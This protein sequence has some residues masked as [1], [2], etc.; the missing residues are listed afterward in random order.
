M[1]FNLFAAASNA[2][3]DANL[4]QT[5]R[6]GITYGNLILQQNTKT[7]DGALI[8]NG[9]ITF[10]NT[11]PTTLALL[12]FDHTFNGG[13]IVNNTAAD[14][15][16][17][18]TSG[19]TFRFAGPDISQ[20]LNGSD[21]GTYTFHN[22]I[23]SNPGTPTA[24]RT[25][26]IQ[27]SCTV[28]GDITID[29]ALGDTINLLVVNIGANQLTK[30][31]ASGTLTAGAFTAIYTSG[32]S[33]FDNTVASFT[34]RSLAQNSIVRF[35][36]T[37]QNIPGIT[38]GT[39]EILGTGTKTV[40]GAMDING[41]LTR[42]ANNAVIDLGAFSHTLAGDLRINS[43]AL[44]IP[45]TSTLTLDGGNQSILFGA[46]NNVIA[47]GTGTK[48]L[49]GS[50]IVN[51][52]LTINN[53]VTFDA[54]IRSITL[55][56]NFINSGTGVFTQTTGTVTFNGTSASA[57][58][59]TTNAAS[60]FG[61]VFFNRPNASTSRTIQALSNFRVATNCS[62]GTGASNNSNVFDLNGF[63]VQVAG[64]WSFQGTSSSFLANNGTVEFNGTGTGTQLIQNINA[65]ITYQSVI[66]S[67]S[68]SKS[69]TNNTFNISGNVTINTGATVSTGV[70]M[71]IGGNWNNSGVFNQTGGTVTFNGGNQTI[72][73][74]NFQGLT[75]AG[76]N[77]KT[78]TGDLN[79]LGNL[80]ISNGATL[81][82][83]ASNFTLNV[84][85]NFLISAGGTFVPRNG[86]VFIN[87]TST[88]NTG[89]SGAGQQ[90]YNL[91]INSSPASV[92]ASN[93]IRVN[94]NLT[95]TTG[96]LAM[97]A[98]NLFIGGSVD[99]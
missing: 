69:L 23:F 16:I 51:G 36:G 38:Y 62:W 59:I 60:T 61:S 14:G 63:T 18:S 66:F 76:T 5:I 2:R 65:A 50:Q 17:T 30:A 28:N 73:T 7:V 33:N 12:N 44:M 9:N 10:S 34:T 25:R 19:G 49:V 57:Q 11:G 71:N 93:A 64:N 27:Q 58:T 80:T 52:N 88:L 72:S 86:T 41:N 4:A 78:L 43:Q 81:D 56:G 79:I 40:T 75:I 24:L 32:T 35:F 48:T 95:I 29:N 91:T 84:D 68:A 83:S 54:N 94:N 47:A 39:I 55:L 74:S 1:A 87:N 20:T 97:G 3:Y 98:N 99:N 13:T 46:L 22:L 21:G 15:S 53:G 31:S 85:N 82:V 42:I 37:T 90:F 89:G 92:T 6:G 45:S 77:T 70:S 26:T 67:N 96:T 8:I